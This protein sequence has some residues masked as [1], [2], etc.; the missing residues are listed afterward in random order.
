MPLGDHAAHWANYLG[1]LVKELSLHYPFWRQMPPERKAGVV[2]KIG[3]LQKIYNG[4]K[5][6]LKER[7]WVPEE[8]GSYDLEGIK[9]ARP[10]HISEADWD[11]QL[12]FWNVPKNLARA[13]QNKKTEQRARS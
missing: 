4:K 9:H 6:A 2:A 12:S 1:E 13:A 3:H 8:D 7:Y 11:A 5:A 10:S